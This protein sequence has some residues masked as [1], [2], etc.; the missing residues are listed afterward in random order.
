M[1]LGLHIRRHPRFRPFR[2]AL[3]GVDSVAFGGGMGGKSINL[4][5]GRLLL[6]PVW[7][8]SC[9]LPFIPTTPE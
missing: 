9:C 1:F 7:I 5:P 4:G 6:Y 2:H 3:G 8:D